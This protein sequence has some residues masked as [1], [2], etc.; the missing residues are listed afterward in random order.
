MQ[1]PVAFMIFNRPD[2]TEQV[3]REIAKARPPKLFVIADG[4]RPEQPGEAQK[5]AAT[6]A[7]VERVDWDCEVVKNYSD[8]N[9]GCGLRVATGV[10]WV[11]QQADR[12]IFL[13]DDCL[14]H[15]TFFRFCEE[16][17]ERYHDD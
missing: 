9:L 7:V 8:V 3:F 14:P 10:S 4:P 11:F 5:C 13:E 16:L 1:V 12:A 2:V 17:L 6:R 15:P